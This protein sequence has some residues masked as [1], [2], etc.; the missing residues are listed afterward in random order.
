[1]RERNGARY[2]SLIYAHEAGTESRSDSN[3]V[4]TIGKL[5]VLNEKRCNILFIFRKRAI[6]QLLY[7]FIKKLY[8]FSGAYME[9]SKVY[10]IRTQN[11][12]HVAL[13]VPVFDTR[14][15]YI[16]LNGSY[17]VKSP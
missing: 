1:M 14:L 8:N 9:F 11:T 6:N 3:L 15:K 17:M 16:L 7:N 2:L 5:G 13:A 4:A 10:A 12:L